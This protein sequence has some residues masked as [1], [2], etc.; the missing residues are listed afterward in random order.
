VTNAFGA[1]AISVVQFHCTTDIYSFGHEL[2]HLMSARHDWSRDWKNNSP[3]AYNHGCTQPKPLNGDDPWRTIMAMNDECL[4]ERNAND[5][6]IDCARQLQWS[7]P[8]GCTKRDLLGVVRSFPETDN[9]RTL[10]NTALTVA[11]F[12]CALPFDVWMR[13]TWSDTG[14]EPDPVQANEPMWK[15]PYIWVRNTAD[16]DGLHAHEHQNP[17]QGQ[18]Q[19]IYVK[20]HNRGAPI[21]GTLEVY[22][23]NAATALS[24]PADWKLLGASANSIPALASTIVKIPWTPA[25]AGHYCLLARWVSARDPMKTPEGL[26]TNANVRAN[27]NLI[28]RNVNVVDLLSQTQSTAS[29]IVRN[30]SDQPAQFQLSIRRNASRSGSA[31]DFVKVQLQLS[32]ELRRLWSEDGSGFRRGARNTLLIEN[33]GATLDGLVLPPR[34]EAPVLV[35]FKR[36]RRE[37]Q[38]D[39]FEIDVVQS[40]SGERAGIVGGVTYDVRTN[41]LGR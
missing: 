34:F 9:R 20:V 19:F 40:A 26:D 16:P 31:T 39:A 30:V 10:E 25:D 5:L 15:S 4:A 14:A 18:E 3:Y 22:G 37:F 38:R 27:N 41:W 36:P 7:D 28:W 1:H 6:P 2:G 23:A 8:N 17:Q 13:D 24:W 12:R 33:D 35:N 32:P 11:N 21:T 29:F